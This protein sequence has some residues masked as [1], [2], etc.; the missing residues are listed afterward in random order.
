MRYRATIYLRADE[1]YTF[2]KD[3]NAQYNPVVIVNGEAAEFETDGTL[4][5]VKYEVNAPEI[6]VSYINMSGIDF[7]EVGKTATAN[8]NQMSL[9][10]TNATTSAGTKTANIWAM[11]TPSRK[12]RLIQ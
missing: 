4:M 2:S 1:G 6:S 9:T 12:V 11:T 10:I 3:Q 5:T 8:P 7:P